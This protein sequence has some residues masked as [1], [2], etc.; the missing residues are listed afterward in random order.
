[1][2]AENIVEIIGGGLL[3]ITWLS[4][5]MPNASNSKVLQVV[6]DVANILSANVGK[7]RNAG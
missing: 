1:M 3:A 7:N 6:F 4:T 5:V 2:N